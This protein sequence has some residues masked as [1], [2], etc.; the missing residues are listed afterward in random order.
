[1]T[2]DYQVYNQRNKNLIQQNVTIKLANNNIVN[3]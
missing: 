1:M 3:S 2:S